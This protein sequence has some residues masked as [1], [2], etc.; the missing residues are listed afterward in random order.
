MPDELS[1]P[2]DDGSRVKIFSL[3]VLQCYCPACKCEFWVKSNV[4]NV[5][6]SC[7]SEKVSMLWV[8]PVVAFVPQ[9]GLDDE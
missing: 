4:V 1:V 2:G 7:I 6:P 8:T 5:C 3:G 9:K